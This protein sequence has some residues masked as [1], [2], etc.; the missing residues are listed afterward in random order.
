V[1]SNSISIIFHPRLSGLV[2]QEGK[3]R[4]DVQS[5]GEREEKTEPSRKR[6]R[7]AIPN[8]SAL[9]CSH[10]ETITSQFRCLCTCGQKK[11]EKGGETGKERRKEKGRSAGQQPVAT[12]SSISF[13]LI[14]P[15][16]PKEGRGKKEIHEEKSHFPFLPS[17]RRFCSADRK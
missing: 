7:L 10:C 14:A 11:R 9:S 2:G 15:H 5:R 17:S 8:K 6:T 13:S 3:G 4:E 12:L 16:S 1:S